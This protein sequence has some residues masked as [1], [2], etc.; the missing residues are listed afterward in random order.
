VVVVVV[1][2]LTVTLWTVEA[3]A[4]NPALPEYAAKRP[5][6]PTGR[7]LVVNVATPEALRVPVPNTVTPFLKVTKPAGV[8]VG[9]GVT[10]AVKV[11][12]CP[13]VAGFGATVKVVVVTVSGLTVT[14]C[15][16]EVAPA[17]PALPENTAVRLN[18]PFGRL[19]VVN[20]AIPKELT[21]P[22]P[23]NVAPLKKFTV[24]RV[25]P[26]GAGVT[27]AV[28]VTDC[29]ENAGFGATL[30]V[31]VVTV[32]ALTV[33]ITAAEVEVVN[34]ALPEKTAVMLDGPSGRLLVVNVATPDPLISTI[35]SDVAPLK[36]CTLSSPVGIG[37]TVA[38]HVT[39]WPEKAGFGEQLS[40]VVVGRGPTA[41][42]TE[43]LASWMVSPG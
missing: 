31:I 5:N 41:T 39:D 28:K 27:V 10:V 7:L 34:P 15:A 2:A 14:L 36:N 19:L 43:K 42:G 25:V 21:V 24:P 38:V 8:P 11:T 18:T 6:V 35:P 12:S 22:L 37:A 33:T 17:N 29:P 3:E 30:R 4:A 26:V 16:V 40:D 32:W 23:N 20:V 13:A 9:A 1:A